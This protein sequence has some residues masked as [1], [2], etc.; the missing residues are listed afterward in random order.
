MGA[1]E[2]DQG[3]EAPAAGDF[4]RRSS[5]QVCLAIYREAVEVRA[6]VGAAVEALEAAAMAVAVAVLEVAL[7]GETFLVEAVRAEGGKGWSVVS[8]Q[9]SVVSGGSGFVLTN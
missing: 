4:G 7:A 8:G 6:A 3:A 5:G 1:A 2:V 9:L